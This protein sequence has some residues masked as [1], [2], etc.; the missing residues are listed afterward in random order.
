MCGICGIVYSDSSKTVDTTILSRM[1]DSLRHRGPDEAGYFVKGNIG[2]GIRRLSIIDVEG[3][4]QPLYNEDRTV[5]AICNGEIYNHDELRRD[6]EKRGHRFSTRSDAEVIVHLYEDLED[7]FVQRLRGMFAIAIWDVREERLVLARDRIGIKPLYYSEQDGVFLFAS[8]PKAILKHPAAERELSFEAL[9]DYLTYLYIPAPET[10]YER[11][12]KLPPA[13]LL[14]YSGGTISL[15]QYWELDYRKKVDVPEEECGERLRDLLRRSVKSHLMSE[16]PLGAF[17]SGGMDSSTI[18]AL[19]SEVTGEPVKTFSVGFDVVDFNELRYAKLVAERFG[20]EHHEIHLKADIVDLLPKIVK[21]LDEPFADSSAIP[22][23]L[24][25]EFAKRKVT[26]C[27]A[28]DG[29]DE[30]FAGYDWTRRQKFVDDFNK[31]PRHAREGLR[32]VLLG[33]HYSPDRKTK[34]LDK[35]KR[36]AFDAGLSPEQSFLRRKTCFSKELQHGLMKPDVFARIERYESISKILPFFERDDI[37]QGLEKL[38]YLDTKLYLP[39]DGLCKVDRMSM[40]HSLEVRVPF[41][42]HEVVEFAASIPFAY[43]MKGFVSKH[44]LKKAMKGVLPPQ[45]LGQRK[46]GF[47]IPLNSWFRRELRGYSSALLARNQCELNRYFNS[48]FVDWIREEHSEGRQDFGPQIFAL[49]VLELWLRDT[50]E[51]VR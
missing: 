20:T 13:H 31:I 26:V 47:T 50:K 1:N 7:G 51:A 30:L 25:S 15:T 32:K 4:H 37:A 8:E 33:A 48:Q 41:L 40:A 27:L 2:L 10:I 43:K 38:L 6:L 45:I 42:D 39:D 44:I 17:L 24:I 3:G 12:R 22:T 18:V 28:G 19:M 21:Q 23:Y 49:L 36:F 35:V 14:I 5:C 29:G 46:L 9:S 16:V 34:L 11:M